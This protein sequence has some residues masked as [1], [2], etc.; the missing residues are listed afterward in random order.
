MIRLY[1]Q[2]ISNLIG[3]S[4]SLANSITCLYFYMKRN[5]ENEDNNEIDEKGKEEDKDIELVEK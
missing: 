2:I 3:L 4:F 1:G 5:K